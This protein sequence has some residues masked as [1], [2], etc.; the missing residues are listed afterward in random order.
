[1]TGVEFDPARERPTSKMSRREIREAE[2]QR[3]RAEATEQER[4]Q[5]RRARRDQKRRDEREN[6]WSNAFGVSDY[7]LET[8]ASSTDAVLNSAHES[9]PSAAQE[10][11]SAP[12]TASR[13]AARLAARNASATTASSVAGSPA[14]ST[15]AETKAGAEPQQLSRRARRLAASE[16]ASVRV[17]ALQQHEASEA[18]AQKPAAASPV[19]PASKKKSWS[20]A[21]DLEVES[22]RDIS[23]ARA[24]TEAEETAKVTPVAA[25]THRD[26]RPVPASVPT[27]E[28]ANVQ[29]VL[30]A[31]SLFAFD[32]E[33]VEAPLTAPV[34]PRIPERSGLK[35]EQ[36]AAAPAAANTA[37]TAPTQVL[38]ANETGPQPRLDKKSGSDANPEQIRR[39][40]ATTLRGKRT[41]TPA[42]AAT[43]PPSK[44]RRKRGA[45]AVRKLAASG[46]LLVAGAFVVATSV[47]AQAL[48]LFGASQSGS[49]SV[50]SGGVTDPDAQTLSIPENVSQLDLMLDGD[51]S[52]QD[53]LE[54]AR[55]SPEQI[56]QIQ[57]VADASTSLPSGYRQGVDGYEEALA[58]L[59]TSY[60]Q[61][62][63]PN[64]GDDVPISSGFEWRWGKVHEGIDFT[65]GAGTDIR[66]MA[67]GIVTNVAHGTVGG[68]YQ[69]TVDHFIDGKRY[70][71]VYAHMIAGSIRVEQGQVVTIDTVIGQ[72]GSTGFSTGPHLHFE[73]RL[74]STEAIDPIRW[75]QNRS[76]YTSTDITGDNSY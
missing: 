61:H 45:I 16:T 42:A 36:R 65:P 10:V 47:P 15:P 49:A 13:R 37:D 17:D 28:T 72:V 74:E 60:V 40:R 76:E 22:T 14:A 32:E 66:P 11:P 4:M 75:L 43:H 7:T 26:D 48:G 18:G 50:N 30:S 9:L 20:L 64:L 70:Q 63:F 46:I 67:N 59:E 57:L 51:I 62:P 39:T 24:Q 1:M 21:E 35:P 54:S 68:G 29:P 3:L 27:P 31:N 5:S 53:A 41:A 56:A 33:D 25:P 6:V 73:I 19:S 2:Q 23:S 69:V 38:G 71:T 52:I 12:R 34:S 58:M 55:L 44:P 8:E